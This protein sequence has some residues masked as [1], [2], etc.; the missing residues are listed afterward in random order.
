[1]IDTAT[2]ETISSFSWGYIRK[3][4]TITIL[5]VEFGQ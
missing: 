1:M 3:G 2:G 4:D 5:K